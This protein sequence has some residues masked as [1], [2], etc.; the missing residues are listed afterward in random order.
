MDSLT[1]G[2]AFFGWLLTYSIHISSIS[3]AEIARN[4]DQ[5]VKS[6]RELPD[7]ASNLLK[8]HE[9]DELQLENYVSAHASMIEFQLINLNKLARSTILNTDEIAKLRNVDCATLDKPLTFNFSLFKVC[10][11]LVNSI[12]ENYAIHLFHENVFRRLYARRL[13]ELLGITCASSVLSLYFM[14]F[15]LFN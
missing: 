6:L 15:Q 7:W 13:P 3:R 12:E 2:I 5:V 14:L 8:D 11:D 4:K 9:P 1:F 10:N